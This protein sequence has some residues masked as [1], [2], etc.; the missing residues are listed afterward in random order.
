MPAVGWYAGG[1]T[2][3]F[4]EAEREARERGHFYR[5]PLA[6]L[7]AL[8]KRQER[9]DGWWLSP[10]S[11]TG[12][13]RKRLL[14]ASE[15]YWVDPEKAWMAFV[16]SSIHGEFEHRGS[17]VV[18]ARTT[19]AVPVDGELV[20]FP[21]AGTCD[22]YDPETRTLLDFKV[23]GKEFYE[24]GEDGRRRARDLLTDEYV[25]Q[26]N[27]Y[28]LLLESNG[29][30]VERA[31]L[32]YVRPVRDAPRKLVE[33]PLWDVETA[34][35]RAVELAEPLA[36]AMVT[37]QLPPCTCAYPA[38]GINPDLCKTVETWDGYERVPA[39]ETEGARERACPT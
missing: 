17:L 6:A 23:T 8:R 36:R 10:S 32:W 11:A 20:E 39:L 15:P 19:L 29:M 22:S 27:L 26:V 33:V 24:T 13:P 7:Q 1:Q 37:G 4:D 16:G 9:V 3:S 21:L 25:T 38:Y 5:F 2:Y 31:F 12:C 35:W 14:M 18:R 28:R 30:P 34:Y